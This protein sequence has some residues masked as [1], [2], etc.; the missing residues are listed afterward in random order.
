M[1]LFF[2]TIL[3]AA[4]WQT[5]R[6]QRYLTGYD[7]TLFLRDTL[8]PIL[9]RL[10]NLHFSGYV[11]P[12]FQAVQ[13]KG[14]PSYAGGNFPDSSNNRFMLRR[15]RMKVDYLIPVKGTE[16][17]LALFTF[18]FDISERGAFARDIF[19]RLGEPKG[20]RLSLTMG[21]FARPFGYEVNLAS[22]FR[23]SPERARMSQ[24]LMPTERDIGAMV[25]YE[26]HGTTQHRPLFKFDAG[27]F[28]GPG[29]AGTTDFDSYKDLISRFILKPYK[30]GKNMTVSAGLSLLY[31]GWLQATKYV[32]HTHT[33]AGGAAFLVD[34]SLA[35]AGAEAPRHYYGADMQWQFLHAHG[36]T[37]LRG[38]YWTG[39]Q[40]GT[41]FT[42]V[43]PGTLPLTPT[44]M[45]RFSGAAFYFLQN[46]VNEHWELVAKYDWYDPNTKVSGRSVGRAGAGF[47][48]ADVRFNT[49]GLGLT[50]YL[51]EQVKILAYYDLVRNERTL[52]PGY[53]ADLKDNV[54]TLRMQLR[55]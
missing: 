41:L 45:R 5:V 20:R 37:E 9:K 24:I 50:H 32:Y 36:K 2:L 44:Y 12:Q 48:A 38:E 40:P 1:A 15:A 19:L 29:L 51:T 17:P 42:T 33:T 54:F 4:S 3:C 7:S 22:A 6:A 35:N 55:F 25:S 21:L 27:L 13:Q 10:E 49:L 11:Q 30:V 46:V 14:A 23:E 18:Q 39:R 52:L 31:G 16:F 47:G 8:R 53:T 34:S 26:S 43:N 28:N